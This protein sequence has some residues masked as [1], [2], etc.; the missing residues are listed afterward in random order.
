M[1]SAGAKEKVEE[2]MMIIKLERMEVQMEKEKNLKK[3]EE[4]EGH[5]VSRH[6]I[7]D[8]IDP[9]FAKEKNIYEDDDKEIKKGGKP[10]SKSVSKNQ[11]VGK[12]VKAPKKAKSAKKIKKKK[13]N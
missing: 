11:K 6:K 8:Y 4:I 3:L 9:K 1:G 13:K 10:K 7:P 5:S 2:Q 12:K